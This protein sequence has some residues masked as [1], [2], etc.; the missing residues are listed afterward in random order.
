MEDKED[1]LILFPVG[2][3]L[4]VILVLSKKLRVEFDIAR[5][6]DSVDVT[7]ASSDREIRANL[8]KSL[9]DVVDVLGLG[10]EGVVVHLLVIH[11]VFFA[12][13]NSN[14]LNFLAVEHL[15]SLMQTRYHFQ[16]LLH[17]CSSLEV[18]RRGS[19]IPIHILFG[20]I[21]HVAGK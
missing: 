14:F 8:G 7:K 9:I 1:G 11:A 6:V 12:A 4:D 3:L 5:L 20:Q 15:G 13:G 21:N 2:F 19:D 18:F 17:G 10:V 16:P